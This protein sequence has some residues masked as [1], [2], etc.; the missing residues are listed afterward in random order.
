MHLPGFRHE[1]VNEQGVILL[2]GM[3]AEEL[4]YMVETVQ[5]GFPD[6]DAKR[7]IAPNR[8]QRVNIEF[9][10]ESRNFPRTWPPLNRV[11]RHCVLAP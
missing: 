8:W 4:G 2:F 5:S 9:E 11:R 10:F 3:V 1:P 7:Q 6:C